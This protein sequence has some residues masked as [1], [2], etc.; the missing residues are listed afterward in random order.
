MVIHILR[1]Y[2]A[3]MTCVAL[4]LPVTACGGP[5]GVDLGTNWAG[6]QMFVLSKVGGLTTVVGIDPTRRR[7]EPLAAVPSQSDDDTVLSPQITRLVDGRWL[8]SVPRKSSQPSR[9]YAVNVKDHTLDSLGTV[10]GG[11]VLLPAGGFAAA[12]SGRSGSPAGKATVLV[13]DP[14]TWQVQRTVDLP[15]DAATA[16]GGPDGLCVGSTT[17]AGTSIALTALS[18][19]ST[20]KLY[21][22]PEFKA[23][24]LDCTSGPPIVGGGPAK[25][26]EAGAALALTLTDVHGLKALAASAG[27]VDKAMVDENS[28]VAAIYLAGHVEVIELDAK[29]GKELRRVNAAGLGDVNGMR[30][31]SSGWVLISGGS[32]SAVDLPSGQAHGFKLP[33]QLLSAG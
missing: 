28:I 3:L 7:A 31:T 21:Q 8:V 15:V 33:G 29:D 26:G 16:S 6:S 22:V 14:A 24:S 27:R 32:A 18:A 12:V 9:L 11:R 19:D 10:E 13:Y 20:P 30:K 23:Q 17:D 2:T 5:D 25:A 1:R 4:T